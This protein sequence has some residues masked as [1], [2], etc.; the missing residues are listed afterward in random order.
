MNEY[1]LPIGGPLSESVVNNVDV[2]EEHVTERV[3]RPWL[4]LSCALLFAAGCPSDEPLGT[5]D[6]DDT[7][8][9]TTG[10]VDPSTTLPPTTDPTTDPTDSSSSGDPT[11]GDPT[12]GSSTTGGSTTDEPTTGTAGSTGEDDSSSTSGEACMFLDCPGECV[13][14]DTNPDFCGATT[15]DGK[16][17]GVVCSGSATC[18]AGECVE[19]CDNCSFESADFTGWTLADLSEPF[20]AAG[21]GADGFDP[22]D[23]FF[24]IV[25][26]TDGTSV[27][28]NG[29]DGNGASDTGEITFGQDLTLRD[30]ATTIE[31]DYRVAWDL[32]NEGTPTIDRTFEVHIEPEG[33]G[34]PME[35]VLV[36]T[37]A[38]GTVGDVTDG[39]SVD[40]SAYAGQTVFINFVWTVP[41][42]F[43]GP[44]RAELD[45]IRVLA[46]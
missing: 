9:S 17:A 15:C 25:T 24:G 46:E 37:A 20:L 41:E 18:E 44:A 19:S 8:G 10:T 29:F 21:V 4:S 3:M 40:V 30:G 35:T 2:G 16:G 28:Y 34:D 33:G 1:G 13:D 6:D 27:A 26:A 45:N 5:N 39:G 32:L 11:I 23:G 43:T 14:P 31:F 38:L 7:G 22:D 12:T 36:E 42:D